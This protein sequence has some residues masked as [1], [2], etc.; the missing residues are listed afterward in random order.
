MDWRSKTSFLV[1]T[2]SAVSI[3]LRSLVSASFCRTLRPMDNTLTAAN[4]L[5]IST[6]GYHPLTL[7]L[8]SAHLLKWEFIIADV[9]FPILGADF[10]RRLLPAEDLALSSS[11]TPVDGVIA[12]RLV[13]SRRASPWER[14]LGRFRPL[15]TPEFHASAPVKHSVRNVIQ[16]SGQ[17]CHTKARHLS[18]AK[19]KTA[20]EYFDQLLWLGIVH[21]SKSTF[22][23][24]L[25]MAPKKDGTWRP[26]RDYRKLNKQTVPNRYPLP[27]IQDVVRDLDDCCIFSKIDLVKAYHQIPMSEEDIMKTAIITPFGLFEYTRTPLAFATPARYFSVSWMR[28]CAV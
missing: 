24:P 23:S 17:P 3:I 15:Q 8:G 5:K 9:T 21:H 6:Y 20:K 19:M 26:C 1:D 4:G 27:H 28:L 25:H 12:A 14:L 13:P 22:A 7:D 18:P 10:L 16:T 11:L 2:G